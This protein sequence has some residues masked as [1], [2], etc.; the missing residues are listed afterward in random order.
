MS[1][2]MLSQ[3]ARL[4]GHARTGQGCRPC[5]IANLLSC[6]VTRYD[7][8]A[9]LD[10]E[11]GPN[12]CR[13][14]AADAEG[15]VACLLRRHLAG[16]FDRCGG[17]PPKRRASRRHDRHTEERLLAHERVRNLRLKLDSLRLS[18]APQIVELDA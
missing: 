18:L 5:P 15:H 3:P 12:S 6:S 1:R 8:D 10:L 9:I 14:G 11:I 7:G 16:D 13:L 4:L 2:Y 17:A